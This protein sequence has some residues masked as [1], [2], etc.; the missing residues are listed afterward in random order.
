MLY[1]TA[2]TEVKGFALTLSIG[3]LG[4]LFTT[5]FVSRFIFDLIVPEGANRGL[6]WPGLMLP[7]VV[8]AI[9]RLL[10]PSID[11]IRWRRVF[12]VFSLV[13]ALVGL[14]LFV[15]RGSDILETEFRGGVSLT[16]STRPAEKGEPSGSN[17]DLLLSLSEVRA[18]L[19]A[20]GE[21]APAG[22]PVSELRNATVLTSGETT[23]DVE[24]TAFP[25]EGCQSAR[26]DR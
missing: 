26:Y 22:S 3:V 16:M 12:Q 18:R 1:Q 19:E 13:L 21:A 23:L 4:T 2:A 15:S 17:G 24:A 9:H 20:A 10:Q 25:G 6:K 5:L 8:P 14:W 11:W 7:V